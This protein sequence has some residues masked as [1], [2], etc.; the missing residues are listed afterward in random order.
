M[1]RGIKNIALGT[2]Q[3]GIDY[4]IN[5]TR[6]KVP[7]DEVVKILAECKKQ[8]I[9]VIDTSRCYGNS[10]EVLGKALDELKAKD[11]FRICTKLDLPTGWE[12]FSF[13]KIKN[14]V[15][16]SVHKSQ[17]ALRLDT[18]PMFLLHTYQYVSLYDGLVWKEVLKLK[19]KGEIKDLGVSICY[20]TDEAFQTL[21]LP[22]ISVI[23]IPFNVF[24]SRWENDGVLDK[25]VEKKVEVINRS[26]FL[27]GLFFMDPKTAVERVPQADG[28]IQKLNAISIENNIPI[29]KL[30]F[31]YVMEENRINYSLLGVDSYKQF[32]ENIDMADKACLDLRIIKE[33]REAFKKVPIELVNP[34]YWKKN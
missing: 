21:N 34:V 29:S 2:V 12:N 14:L 16:D 20:T 22:S 15:H 1:A 17:E 3:F 8:G 31:S 33:L 10:E 28:Y 4:G 6:G 30:V 19:E 5:N 25:C 24:D 32:K 18:I 27:Q 9:K 26:T 7:F 11:D 13:E 23:Q